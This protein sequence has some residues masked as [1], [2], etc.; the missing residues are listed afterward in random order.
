MRRVPQIVLAAT[1]LLGSGTSAS[2]WVQSTSSKGAPLH[3]SD[4][5]H[6][7]YAH[8]DGSDDV[9]GAGGMEAIRLSLEAWNEVDCSGFTFLWAGLTNMSWVGY[10]VHG[11]NANVVI[12]REEAWPYHQR[13]VAFT[14]VTYDP[15][16]GEIMDADLELNGEDYAFT[17]LEHGVPGAVDIRNTVTHEAGHMLGLDHSPKVASTMYKSS[18]LGETVKR[19][20][21]DDDVEGVCHVYPA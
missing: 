8:M 5:C 16:T 13:P 20:L 3:W 17:A 7:V 2:A 21:D 1:L 9:E 12:F 15:V 4:P 10:S 19:S 11:G 6:T 18:I 14:S